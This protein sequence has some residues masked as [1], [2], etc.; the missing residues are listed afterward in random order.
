[1]FHITG[2]SVKEIDVSLYIWA[3]GERN[4]C[5]IITGRS[6]KEIDVSL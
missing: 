4:R 5:F 1:M 2:R 3:V 6:V